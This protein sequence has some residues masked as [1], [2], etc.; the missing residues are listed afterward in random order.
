M[1]VFNTEDDAQEIAEKIN[2]IF[3]SFEMYEDLKL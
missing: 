3:H 2:D 1:N